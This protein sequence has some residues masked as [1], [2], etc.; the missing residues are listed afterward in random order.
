MKRQE[1]SPHNALEALSYE[2]AK[3]LVALEALGLEIIG[4]YPCA[5]LDELQ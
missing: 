4:P 1:A 2:I 3:A 5:K